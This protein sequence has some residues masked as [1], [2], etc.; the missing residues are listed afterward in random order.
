MKSSVHQLSPGESI[1]ILEDRI[2]FSQSKIS[3]D[4]T[5]QLIWNQNSEAGYYAQKNYRLVNITW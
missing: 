4:H 5:R 1:F 3:Q 2:L